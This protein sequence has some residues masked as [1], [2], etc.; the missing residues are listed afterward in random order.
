[1]KKKSNVLIMSL[2]LMM[3]LLFAG[4]S[5]GKDA[6]KDIPVSGSFVEYDFDELAE[7]AKII[8]KV[9]M[10]DTLTAEKS[11]TLNDPETGSMGG[12]Y[13]ER[14]ASVIEYYK[15]STGEFSDDL[16]FI[17]P[18]A[19]VENTY[20]HMDDYETLQKGEEYIIFLS[21]GTASGDMS[22]IS[23]NNGVVRLSD[24]E[25]DMNFDHIKEKALEMKSVE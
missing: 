7:H 15:D 10:T 19:I 8:A 2:L 20:Y 24:K 18:A 17:E 1:M 14:T 23:A 12:F 9:E 13:G 6:V 22:I 25:S 11:H 21:D 16:M 4:C 3:S 5:D